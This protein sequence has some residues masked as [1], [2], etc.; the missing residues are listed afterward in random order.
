MTLLLDKQKTEYNTT[1]RNMTKQ[2]NDKIAEDNKKKLLQSQQDYQQGAMKK[3]HEN[4]LADLKT[5]QEDIVFTLN[6]DND[7]N[8]NQMLE[9][10][11]AA[12]EAELKVLEIN[13]ALLNQDLDECLDSL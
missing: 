5:N 3:Q 12:V 11:K 8:L 13:K 6:V 1:A 4:Q 10:H 9:N 7:E 2:L